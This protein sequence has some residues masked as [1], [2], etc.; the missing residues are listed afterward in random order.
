MSTTTRLRRVARKLETE[1]PEGLSR[2]EMFLASE[3]LLPVSSEKKTWN[4][5]NF[6]R[7]DCAISLDG[8]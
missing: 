7:A 3:D 2:A 4:G 8:H 5:W 6:V 1:H